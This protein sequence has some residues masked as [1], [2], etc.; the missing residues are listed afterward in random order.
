MSSTSTVK[1]LNV[2]RGSIKAEVKNRE[3]RQGII[4]G[5]VKERSGTQGDRGN[6]ETIGL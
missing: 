4:D 5:L 3:E 1:L 2:D 6:E